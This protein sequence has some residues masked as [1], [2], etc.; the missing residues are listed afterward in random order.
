MKT[1]GTIFVKILQLPGR[2]RH[3]SPQMVSLHHIQ[4]PLNR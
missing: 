2:S 1:Y 3:F 4:R